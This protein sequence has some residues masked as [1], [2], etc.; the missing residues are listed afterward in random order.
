MKVRC[1]SPEA[2]LGMSREEAAEYIG[3]GPNLF[4]QMVKDSRMPKPKPIGAR[5][6]WS[7]PEIE[8]AFA[9][10]PHEGHDEEDAAVDPWRETS[11]V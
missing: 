7:R 9:L 11:V 10:L 3:I 1:I 8:K 2:R 6:V 4:D 5:R